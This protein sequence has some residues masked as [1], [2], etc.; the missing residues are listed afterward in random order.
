MSTV[1]WMYKLLVFPARHKP[2]TEL[3]LIHIVMHRI[4][5]TNS[6]V[7]PPRSVPTRILMLRALW[8]VQRPL[9]VDCSNFTWQPSVVGSIKELMWL[10]NPPS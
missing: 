4:E 7:G 5:R 3:P 9:L 10:P 6:L 8:T 2:A 1:I